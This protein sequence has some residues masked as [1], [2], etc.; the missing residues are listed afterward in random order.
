MGSCPVPSTK[1]KSIDVVASKFRSF[2]SNSQQFV[3]IRAATWL[4]CRAVRQPLVE[5]ELWGQS[6]KI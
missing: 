1:R 2:H 3:D 5:N 6:S 4:T